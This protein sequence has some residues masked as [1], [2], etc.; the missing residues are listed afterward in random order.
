M[1]DGQ[2]ANKR[3]GT[4]GCVGLIVLALACVALIAVSEARQY[5]NFLHGTIAFNAGDCSEAISRFEKITQDSVWGF[6]NAAEQA[7][8]Y[9]KECETFLTADQAERSQEFGLAL[10]RLLDFVSLYPRSGLI[11]YVPNRIGDIL[12]KANPQEIA[13]SEVCDRVGL[14]GEA[15]YIPEPEIYVPEILY[16]CSLTYE[17]LGDFGNALIILYRLQSEYPTHDSASSVPEGIARNEIALAKEAG[18]QPIE[19]PMASGTA[20]LGVAVYVVQNDSPERLQIILHGPEVIIEEIEKCT[21]CIEY[22]SDPD[23]CPNKGP[24]KRLTLSPGNYEVLVKSID[25]E[26]VTPYQGSW[27]FLSA[28]E[29]AR[30]YF[31]VE[32]TEP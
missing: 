25:D 15:R 18:A 12:G 28:K 26:D 24:S 8:Q 13:V 9:T 4:R 16:N 22:R 31:I 7:N 19:Q 29:Y 20:P 14:M 17:D 11:T 3:S 23:S 32:D 5:F 21:S 10:S 30:C 27:R 2:S 6:A 1:T